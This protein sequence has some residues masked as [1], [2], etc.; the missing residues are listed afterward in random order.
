MPTTCDRCGR[1]TGEP[2]LGR[3]ADCTRLVR[4]TITA[5]RRYLAVSIALDQR[6]L[7]LI[8]DGHRNPRPGSADR[9]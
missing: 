1:I 7:P 5:L 3:C 8:H 2:S 6:T 4:L 9:D